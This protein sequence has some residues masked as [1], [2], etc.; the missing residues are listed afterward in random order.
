MS[1]EDFYDE[2]LYEVFKI[3]QNPDDVIVKKDTFLEVGLT[4]L[5]GMHA[6]LSYLCILLNGILFMNLIITMIE[7]IILKKD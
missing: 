2:A 6:E 3:V 7:K 4:V 5:V 1:P